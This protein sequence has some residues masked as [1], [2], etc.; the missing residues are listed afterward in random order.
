M[1]NG[2][3]RWFGKVT[4]DTRTKSYTEVQG[5]SNGASLELEHQISTYNRAGDLAIPRP[6]DRLLELV[7]RSMGC[8]WTWGSSRYCRPSEKGPAWKKI[9]EGRRRT[10]IMQ[11]DNNNS[12]RADALVN[13]LGKQGILSSLSLPHESNDNLKTNRCSGQQMTDLSSRNADL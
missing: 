6:D 11:V 2:T 12:V 9:R 1:L 3:A 7:S 13:Q 5:R 8:E 4:R 10:L